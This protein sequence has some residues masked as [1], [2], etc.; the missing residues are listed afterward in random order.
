MPMPAISIIVP[1]AVSFCAGPVAQRCTTGRNVRRAPDAF[2][3]NGWAVMAACQI[4]VVSLFVVKERMYFVL[5]LELLCLAIGFGFGWLLDLIILARQRN[6]N[7]DTISQPKFVD[8]AN[9]GAL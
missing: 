5:P 6:S 4:F 1:A 8:G 2:I 7:A 3:R 9:G